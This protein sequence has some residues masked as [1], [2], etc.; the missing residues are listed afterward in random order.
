MLPFCFLISTVW[1]RRRF[2]AEQFVNQ[3]LSTPCSVYPEHFVPRLDVADDSLIANLSCFKIWS[4]FSLSIFA[5][6]RILLYHCLSQSAQSSLRAYP[7]LE[8]PF[9]VDQSPNYHL[10][11]TVGQ[12]HT[13]LLFICTILNCLSFNPGTL[14]QQAVPRTFGGSCN[15]SMLP[16]SNSWWFFSYIATPSYCI[17]SSFLVQ[18][19]SVP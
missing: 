18:R 1:V 16:F 12:Y 11:C 6:W 3:N 9:S 15:L 19:L 4:N 14:G 13:C 7:Y 2:F 5:L 10:P 8:A 17:P